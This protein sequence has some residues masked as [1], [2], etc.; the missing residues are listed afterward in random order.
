MSGKGW[1]NSALSGLESRLDTMLADEDQP[2]AK[3]RI[4]DQEKEKPPV[5]KKLTVES[6][7]SSRSRPS[8][9]LQD[10]LAKAVN[11][12]TDRPESRASSE[13]ASR[14]ESPALHTPVATT[15]TDGEGPSSEAKAED[16]VAQMS[17]AAK[18]KDVATTNE[19]QNDIPPK[20]SSHESAPSVS[21][22][23]SSSSTTAFVK[24]QPVSTP[25][26]T[27][28]LPSIVTPQLPSPRQSLDTDSTRQSMD[29]V[30][31][32]PPRIGSARDLEEPE[33][34]LSLLQDTHEEN[35]RDSREEL[36]A[37]LER[38]DALQS[39]LS[40]LS[41]QLAAAAK[42]VSLDAEATQTEKKLA[43]KDGQ[44][45]ALMEEGQKL[46]KAEMKH[47]TTIKQMRTKAQEQ[48]K[49]IN[50]FKQRLSK[51]EKSITEQS[52][53]AKRAEGAERSAQEKLKIVSKIEKDFEAIR[54]E[55]EE[56]GLTISELR[57][58]LN[59][60]VSRSESAERR[61]QSG[62][63]ESEK[64]VAASLREDIESLKIEKKL[65]E[66]RAKRELQTSQEDRKDHQEKSKIAELELRGEIA[67]IFH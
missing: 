49:E 42:A 28:S 53:R 52:E 41:E 25:V 30:S 47:L 9:R 20:L 37:H 4:A 29:A 35:L 66:D 14:P 18:E 21:P 23:V 43:D 60:A 46:S 45:A 54:A 6:R 15:A 12:G 55:K 8:S 57:R 63:L 39:K 58:Q 22:Q 19:D 10:R 67:V 64:K 7:N 56:A 59:D 62:A 3:S 34:E 16:L 44:I 1:W 33:S 13:V 11:K 48:A 51:A 17:P 38:I 50:T 5:D 65:A 32:I 26:P 40:Y 36:N 24:E 27:M 61:A 2:G 31:P